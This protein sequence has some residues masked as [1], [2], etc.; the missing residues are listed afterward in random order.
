MA[1]DYKFDGQ[2]LVAI[3]SPLPAEGDYESLLREYGFDR[4]LECAERLGSECGL[5]VEILGPAQGERAYSFVVFFGDD[6]WW[7][8]VWCETVIELH[9]Y[10]LHVSPLLLA[11]QVR[12]I[13]NRVESAHD[14]LFGPGQ[15]IFR[16][17]VRRHEAKIASRLN[18]AGGGR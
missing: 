2:R 6:G 10:L 12:D 15:G 7:I 17:H 8:G 11:L 5:H 18:A 4:P 9:A 14:W 3:E 13:R 1:T 16:D